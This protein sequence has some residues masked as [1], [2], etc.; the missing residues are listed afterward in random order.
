MKLALQE[1]V[2][3]D[4]LKSLANT[5]IVG[6]RF[7]SG[8]VTIDKNYMQLLSDHDELESLELRRATVTDDA[9]ALLPQFRNLTSLHIGKGVND[10]VL[11]YVGQLP[12]L[13]KLT[14]SS[15]DIIGTGMNHIAKLR[16]LKSLNLGKSVNWLW[17][18]K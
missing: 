3:K 5:Q 6:A 15:Y 13:E 12:N 4:I 14:L 7:Q 8:G 1:V 10:E 18:F 9:Y 17:F 16:K 2:S 11:E